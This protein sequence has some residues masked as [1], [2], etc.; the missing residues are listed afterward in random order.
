MSPV[1][2]LKYTAL[3]ALVMCWTLTPFMKRHAIGNL[4]SSEYFVV[5]FILT[6][7]LAAGYWVYLVH[8][9]YAP[10]NVFRGMTRGE[11]CYSVVAALLSVVG[12]ICLI[13][14]VKHYEVSHILPQIQP[15]VLV[16]T[17]MVGFCVFGERLTCLKAAGVGLVVTGVWLINRAKRGGAS[18]RAAV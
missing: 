11:I 17:V 4:T 14:L 2:V 8:G 16:L 7:T 3:A 10:L 6:A 15:L 12:A 18:P 1:T 9:K 13:Y 5:N